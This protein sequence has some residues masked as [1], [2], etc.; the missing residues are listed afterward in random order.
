M[1][2]AALPGALAHLTVR[3]R[4]T[5]GHLA[6]AEAAHAAHHAALAVSGGRGRRGGLLAVDPEGIGLTLGDVRAGEHHAVGVLDAGGGVDRLARGVFDHD[7]AARAD[8]EAAGAL[9]ALTEAAEGAAHAAAAEGHGH[10]GAGLL[11]HAGDVHGEERAALIGALAV[12]V[13]SGVAA[14]GRAEHLERA[15]VKADAAVGVHAV[16][17]RVDDPVAAVDVDGEIVVAEILVGGVDA[18]VR[19]AD[20]AAAGAEVDHCALKALFAGVDGDLRAARGVLLAEGQRIGRMERVVARVDGKRAARDGEVRVTVEGIVLRGDGERAARD[21]Q[22]A[23][24]LDAVVPGGELQ[25]AARD[26]HGAGRDCVVLVGLGLDGVA[27]GVDGDIAAADDDRVVAGDAVVRGGDAQRHAVL[28]GDSALSAALDAVL[29]LRAVRDQRAV[30]GDG[31]AGAGLDLDRRAV[32][33]VGH[34]FVRAVL[35]RGILRVGEGH[36]AGDEEGDLAFLVAAQRGTVGAGKRQIVQDQRH[37]GGALLDGD[38]AVAAR[39]GD[40]VGA[41]GADG[42]RRAVDFIALGVRRGGDAGIGEGEGQFAFRGLRRGHLHGCSRVVRRGVV[43]GVVGRCAGRDH[44]K[45]QC[46]R[47][48][49]AQHDDDETFIG[50]LHKSFLLLG[51]PPRGGFWGGISCP[52]AVL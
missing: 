24:G 52:G 2:S 10:A 26:G 15:A 9:L 1:R 47:G 14:V 40:A 29:A 41:R 33:G 21:G 51:V 22:V 13:Q 43:L 20:A 50:R 23:G 39:A 12:I 4:L 3:G 7:L 36:G 44:I 5:A 17:V 35:V 28:H 6:L 19:G 49:R 16:A 48:K 42:Q 18:V 45:R 11:V 46:Q 38:A 32:K 8:R 34:G 37:A 25:G 27:V 30:A 31:E